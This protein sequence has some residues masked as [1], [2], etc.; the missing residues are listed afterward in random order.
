MKICVTCYEH[1]VAP[2]G[3]SG[4]PSSTVVRRVKHW[5]ILPESIVQANIDVTG[6]PLHIV[7]E[8]TDVTGGFTTF[9]QRPFNYYYDPDSETLKYLEAESRNSDGD[10]MSLV[11]DSRLTENNSVPYALSRANQV[12]LFDAL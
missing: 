9:K 2:D 11:G 7:L 1:T 3:Q 4:L 10:T 12:E 6:E 5:S 8:D